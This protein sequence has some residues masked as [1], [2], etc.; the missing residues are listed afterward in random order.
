MLCSAAADGSLSSRRFQTSARA[1]PGRGRE[2][3]VD[4]GQ[5]VVGA[6]PVERL[7]RGDGVGRGVR[8]RNRLSRARQHLNAGEERP[9][10]LDGFDR[11]DPRPGLGEEPTQLARAGAEVDHR[12][13]RPQREPPGKPGDRLDGVARAAPRVR[14]R[15]GGEAHERERMNIHAQTSLR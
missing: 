10:L 8:K 11:D 9:H 3:A 15:G 12:P 5:R 14:L 1:E 6:E 7:R 4:L 13:T 2:D